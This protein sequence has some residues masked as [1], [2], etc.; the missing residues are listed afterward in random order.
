M[1]LQ[2]AFIIALVFAI[3]DVASAQQSSREP[4]IGYV[5]PAG[6]KQGSTFQIVIGGQ[7]LNGAREA[8]INGEGINTKFIEYFRPMSPQQ[9]LTLRDRMKELEDRKRAGSAT[10]PVF[11][12]GD[13]KELDDI[14][15]KLANF[16]RRPA[17]PAVAERA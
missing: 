7:F 17:T 4:H 11:G 3:A 9:A 1:K 12:V 6:G 16:I 5:Y 15:K 2:W 13:Q 8:R 14:R 10:R